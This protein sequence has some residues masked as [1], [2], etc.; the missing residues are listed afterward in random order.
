MGLWCDLSTHL[1]CQVE[2]PLAVSEPAWTYAAS[3]RHLLLM[4]PFIL[5]LVT[6]LS[7][8]F[9]AANRCLALEDH[10]FFFLFFWEKTLT[11]SAD[12]KDDEHANAVRERK[13]HSPPS[14]ALCTSAHSAC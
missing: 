13:H 3:S 8:S 5:L 11:I 7:S 14:G 10:V 1:G 12:S 6:A 2:V 4:P 9:A